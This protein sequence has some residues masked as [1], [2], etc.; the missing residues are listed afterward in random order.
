LRQSAGKAVPA[1]QA[2]RRG[3]KNKPGLGGDRVTQ[4]SGVESG[5]QTWWVGDIADKMGV[6]AGE[7]VGFVKK[8]G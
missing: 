5:E 3:Q 6:A 2:H 1:I 7:P 8:Q 4:S